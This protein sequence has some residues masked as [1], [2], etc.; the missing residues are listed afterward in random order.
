MSSPRSRNYYAYVQ[1]KLSQTASSST[2]VTSSTTPEFEDCP[3]CLNL[4]GTI[5]RCGYNRKNYDEPKAR[6]GERMPFVSQATYVEGREIDIE[7]IITAYHKGHF[8]FK[9]CVLSAPNEVPSQ[10]CFDKH[11]L[12]FV[13]DLLYKAGK[14]SVYPNRAYLAADRKRFVHRMKLPD[15][16]FGK[17]VL[18]QWHWLTASK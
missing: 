7:T 5:A 12:M 9:I 8:E 1:T 18:L 10:E 15:G 6:D 16:V 13:K 2:A 3:H 11:P 4:G 17:N 14:D